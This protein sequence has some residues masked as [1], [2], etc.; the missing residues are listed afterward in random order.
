MTQQLDTA[1]RST[2]ANLPNTAA[3]WTGSLPQTFGTLLSGFLALAYS[4]ETRVTISMTLTTSQRLSA[5]GHDQGAMTLV[6][7]ASAPIHSHVRLQ[8]SVLGDVPALGRN[9]QVTAGLPPYGIVKHLTGV[10][11]P[12]RGSQ[13]EQEKWPWS[14]VGQA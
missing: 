3:T 13:N 10:Y 12:R 4:L 2:I 8:G 7:S 14:L 6:L 5:G 11:W 9:T 1:Y